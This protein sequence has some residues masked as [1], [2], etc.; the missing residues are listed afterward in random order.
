VRKLLRSLVEAFDGDESAVQ[1]IN[2]MRLKLAHLSDDRLRE[3]A[4]RADDLLRFT[5]AAAIIVIPAGGRPSGSHSRR[6]KRG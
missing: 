4:M 2:S 5:A 1:R 3:A 6:A